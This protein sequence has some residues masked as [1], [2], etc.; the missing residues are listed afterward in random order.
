[1]YFRCPNTAAPRRICVWPY[2][3]HLTCLQS[4]DGCCPGELDVSPRGRGQIVVSVDIYHVRV[5]AIGFIQGIRKG[6]S[7]GQ[8]AEVEKGKKNAP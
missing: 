2:N 5:A 3:L 4:F 7:I 6:C 8:E 1:M